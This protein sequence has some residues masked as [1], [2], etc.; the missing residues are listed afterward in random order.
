MRSGRMRIAIRTKAVIVTVELVNNATL[1][2]DAH[3]NSGKSSK[4]S[5]RCLSSCRRASSI[6]ALIKAVFP[7]PGPPAIRIFFLLWIKSRTMAS[8]FLFIRPVDK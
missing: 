1:F 3:C 4:I 2:E 7:E 5:K 8:C 6:N